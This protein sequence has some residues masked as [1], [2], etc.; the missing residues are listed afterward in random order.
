MAVNPMAWGLGYTYSCKDE[1]GVGQRSDRLDSPKCIGRTQYELN[2]DGSVHRIIYPP[3]SDEEQTRLE[4]C[5]AR[6]ER[7][8]LDREDLRRLKAKYPNETTLRKDRDIRLEDGRHRIARL[9]ESIAKLVAE[10]K[11][12]TDDAEF[13]VGKP[14][15]PDL[16][17]KLEANATSISAQT[18]LLRTQQQE[19]ADLEKQFSDQ[20]D[21]LKELWAHG[22]PA[23]KVVCSAH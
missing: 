13:Y 20:L 12:L 21:R 7:E 19:M 18:D 14:L 11:P 23:L 6:A 22:L 1:N 17:R 9:Q 4:E 2:N 10:R 5:K 3:L 15:P 8:T 16:K